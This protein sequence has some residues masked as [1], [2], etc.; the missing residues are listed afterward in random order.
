MYFVILL[1][2]MMG[3]CALGLF[4]GTIGLLTDQMHLILNTMSYIILIFTGANFPISQLPFLGRM[5]AQM[6]PLSRSI[7]AAKMIFADYD[8]TRIFELLLGEFV[9]GVIYLMAAK[10]LLYFTERWA[11]KKG[12]LELF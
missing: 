10:A 12:T 4:L 3:A 11:I 1:F 5:I 6:L 7:E 2:A 9:V 8:G